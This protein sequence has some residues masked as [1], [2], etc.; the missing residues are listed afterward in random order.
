MRRLAAGIG[1]AL[2]LTVAAA[3]PAAAATRTPSTYET[4]L[5]Q[6]LATCQTRTH[7]S[8]ELTACVERLAAP[9]PAVPFEIDLFRAFSYCI[10]LTGGLDELYR[11]DKAV[12]DCLADFGF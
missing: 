12:Q 7:D 8:A 4:E 11:T 1:L 2:A 3:A 9:D 6:A 5:F 10:W